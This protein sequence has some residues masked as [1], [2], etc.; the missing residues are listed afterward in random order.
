LDEKHQIFDSYSQLSKLLIEAINVWELK[1]FILEKK[2]AND[3]DLKDKWWLKTFEIITNKVLNINSSLNIL[4]P[5]YVLYDLRSLS[6]HLSIES[7]ESTYNGCK[8]RLEFQEW[9][10]LEFH[11]CVILKIIK[12]FDI[13]IRA[14]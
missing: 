14:L 3:L 4:C 6:D 2:I 13:L 10:F 8:S 12:M 5:L 7:F 1:K 11:K 9:W